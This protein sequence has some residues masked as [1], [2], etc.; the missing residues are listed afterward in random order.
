MALPIRKPSGLSAIARDRNTSFFHAISRICQ[1][2]NTIHR[3]KNSSRA[4]VEGPYAVAEIAQ[5]YF[6]TLFSSSNPENSDSFFP[7]SSSQVTSRINSWLLRLV[8]SEEAKQAAFS[9]NPNSAPGPNG[10]TEAVLQVCCS[11]WLSNFVI[12]NIGCDFDLLICLLLIQFLP[13]RLFKLDLLGRMV[14]FE[15]NDRK[16]IGLGLTGFGV[17]FSF[18]GI[19]FFFD[20]GL[21]AMGN[22][23]FLFRIQS[24]SLAIPQKLMY[25]TVCYVLPW[26]ARFYFCQV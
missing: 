10:F 25:L 9:S 22:V 4:W 15:M 26:Y 7:P 12:E 23:S 1:S 11:P 18:L 5:E 3:L 20:K 24:V 16:K 14:S 2:H 13:F 21:L 17:F 8:S 19:I 6:Q